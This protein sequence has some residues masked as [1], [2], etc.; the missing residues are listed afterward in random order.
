MKRMVYDI[1]IFPPCCKL[2]KEIANF[3]NIKLYF[4]RTYLESSLEKQTICALSVSIKFD[5]KVVYVISNAP[6]DFFLLS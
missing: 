4:Y 3:F 6:V 5:F 2:L 1:D